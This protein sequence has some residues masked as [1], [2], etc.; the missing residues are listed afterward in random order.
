[1]PDDTDPAQNPAPMIRPFLGEIPQAHPEPS[2]A[3]PERPRPNALGTRPFLLTSGRAR[4]VDARLEMEAQVLTT[5][6]GEAALERYRYEQ[7]DIVVLCRQ[8]MSVAEVAARLGLHLGVARVL[9]GDLV[10][11]GHLSARRPAGGEHRNVAI[12]ERVIRGLQAIR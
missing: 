8:S 12:I 4:P 11:C 10:A 5:E 1:M 3:P 6:T 9:V 2:G 7:H